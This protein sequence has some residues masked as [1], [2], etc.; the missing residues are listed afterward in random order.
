MLRHLNDL[1]GVT[2]YTKN[3]IENLLE[4]DN[5]NDYVF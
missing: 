1:G 5:E 4:I 3:I 2:V